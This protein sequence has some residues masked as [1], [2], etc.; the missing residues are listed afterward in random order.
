MRTEEPFKKIKEWSPEGIDI[1][2]DPVGGNYFEDNINV[3][4]MEG[5]L[6]I[7]NGLIKV[8]G[9]VSLEKRLG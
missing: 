9:G 5:R 7:R 1:I 3:L 4:S 6:V 2:L 8:V